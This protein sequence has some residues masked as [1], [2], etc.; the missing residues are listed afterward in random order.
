MPAHL[1]QVV[2]EIEEGQ[3]SFHL[4]DYF[5]GQCLL[6][7][8]DGQVQEPKGKRGKNPQGR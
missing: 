1:L 5:H 2:L 6:F 4:A 7:M 8:D 3:V